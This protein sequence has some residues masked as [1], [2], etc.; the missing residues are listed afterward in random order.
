MRAGSFSRILACATIRREEGK[1]GGSNQEGM[2]HMAIAQRVRQHMQAASWI[3]GLSCS[4][5]STVVGF[6]WTKNDSR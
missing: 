1:G 6:D 2:I 4:M 3:R 5:L